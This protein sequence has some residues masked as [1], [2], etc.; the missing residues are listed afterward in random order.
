MRA[1][2]NNYVKD[3]TVTATSENASYPLENLT[4][5]FLESK[6]NISLCGMN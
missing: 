3:S 6:F 1:L 5:V 2:Y 4:H